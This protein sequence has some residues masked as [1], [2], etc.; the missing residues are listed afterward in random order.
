MP[1]SDLLGAV[2]AASILRRDR[3][4]VSRW[5]VSG[6]LPVAAIVGGARVFRREDVY[7]LAGE[8][9]NETLERLPEPT[10]AA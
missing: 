8:V 4:T 1:D 10:E 5:A 2:E 6:K 9:R 7:R 3:A